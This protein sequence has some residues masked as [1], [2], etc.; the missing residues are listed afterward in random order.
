[1]TRRVLTLTAL[2]CTGLALATLPRSARGLR[3]QTP[4]PRKL[5]I[6]VAG[7]TITVNG[8]KLTLPCA[9]EELVKV[10]G[11]QTR[12][13]A[14]A[15]RLLTWDDLGIYAYQERDG[16]KVHV[17]AITFG[18]GKAAFWPKKA[19]AGTLQVN[20]AKVDGRTTID[21][22]NRTT[23]KRFE[24]DK[25]LPDCYTA[26]DGKALLSLREPPQGSAEKVKF[27]EFS[28]SL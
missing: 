23:G 6:V 9:R 7:Q 26:R 1:M 10:L 2:A 8:K 11:A 24:R 4:D 19:F 12:E 27:L 18:K 3:A 25:V 5:E 16:T 13:L 15:N 14:L 20:G 21:E 17:L 28:L 22:I